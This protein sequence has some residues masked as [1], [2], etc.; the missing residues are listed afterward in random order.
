MSDLTP[1]DN[2]RVAVI[3]VFFSSGISLRYMG[4]YRVF[5]LTVLPLKVV[6]VRLHSKSRLKVP[7]VRIS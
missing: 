1:I 3:K 4:M 6:S 2:G 7:S 5:F